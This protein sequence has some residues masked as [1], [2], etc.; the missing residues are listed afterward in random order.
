MGNIADRDYCLVAGTHRW[1]YA[2]GEGFDENQC[3]ACAM[4]QSD[5]EDM[6]R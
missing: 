5:Y 2:P 6:G 3:L 1:L 4:T